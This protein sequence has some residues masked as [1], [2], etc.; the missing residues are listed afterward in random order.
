MEALY[1]FIPLYSLRNHPLKY[2]VSLCASKLYSAQF[3]HYSIK[4]VVSGLLL[5]PW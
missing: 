3:S 5:P 2:Q 4:N 1:S